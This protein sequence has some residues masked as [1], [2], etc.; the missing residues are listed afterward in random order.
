MKRQTWFL[1]VLLFVAVSG[2]RHVPVD[3]KWE[4]VLL[5]QSEPKEPYSVVGEAS[6]Y[7]GDREKLAERLQ[8]QSVKLGAQAVIVRS[9]QVLPGIE[10]P[11]FKMTGTAIRF[12]PEGSASGTGS[13]Q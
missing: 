4:D 9:T 10:G 1:F 13:N 3:G 7:A 12:A 5:L 6:A 8:Y 2:C 11:L